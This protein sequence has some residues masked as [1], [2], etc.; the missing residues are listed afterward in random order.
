MK[1]GKGRKERRNRGRTGRQ[2][3]FTVC[4]P[5][6][7]HTLALYIIIELLVMLPLPKHLLDYSV[8][9]VMIRQ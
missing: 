6:A 8:Y 2:L 7:K 3:T 1:G 5:H 9:Q 4:L